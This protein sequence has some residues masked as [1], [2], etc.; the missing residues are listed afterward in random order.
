[1]DDRR[2]S[3]IRPFAATALAIAAL[4]SAS[5]QALPAPPARSTRVIDDSDRVGPRG[6]VESPR[7]ARPRRGSHEAPTCR[8]RRMIF[9]VRAASRRQQKLDQLLAD[10]QEPAVTAVPQVAYTRPVRCSASVSV[11]RTWQKV[12]DWLADQGFRVDEV[13]RGRGT[14]N[15]SG[16]ALVRS[17]APSGRRNARLPDPKGKLRH[18]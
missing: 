8:W 1:M 9:S 14:V 11:T 13:T 3:L 4:A 7:P 17:S 16:T 5:T 15:F 10:Q 18:A 12:T 6:D 2:R